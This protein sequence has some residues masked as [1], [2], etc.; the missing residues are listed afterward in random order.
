MWTSSRNSICALGLSFVDSMLEQ[1]C[2]E[3]ACLYTPTSS[4]S[5]VRFLRNLQYV[6]PSAQLVPKEGV[7]VHGLPSLGSV[8]KPKLI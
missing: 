2:N 7:S 1:L 6:V 3:H 4:T 8:E 5:V